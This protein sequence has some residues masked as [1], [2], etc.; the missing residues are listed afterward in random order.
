[1]APRLQAKLLRL[2]ESRSF[3]RVGGERPIPFKARLIC[4]TNADL[5]AC[6]RNGT[7]REDLYYRINV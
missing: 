7:F 5:A 4:A 6:V 1:L 2:I 3:Q